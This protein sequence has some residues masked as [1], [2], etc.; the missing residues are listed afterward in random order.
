MTEIINDE[1]SYSTYN[2]IKVIMHNETG[3]INA[4]KVCSLYGKRYDNYARNNKREEF[5]NY[6]STFLIKGGKNKIYTIIRGSYVHKDIIDDV[7]YWCQNTKNEQPEK[8]I[9][10]KLVSNIKCNYQLEV[11]V[12]CGNIDIL[13]DDEIIEVKE[14]SG[15]GWKHALG[16]ILIYGHFYS[17]KKMRVHLF[18]VKNIDIDLIKTIYK[19]HN[20]ELSYE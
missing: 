13:T 7:I 16:Q 18:S 1:Y 15:S 17:D 12:S 10:K 19:K 11:P 2:N 20:V 9:V 4:T 5:I 8:E 3:F 14:G 6:D